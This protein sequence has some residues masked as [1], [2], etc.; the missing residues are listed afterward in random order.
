MP[1]AVVTCRCGADLSGVSPDEHAEFAPTAAPATSSSALVWSAAVVAATLGGVA[2]GAIWFRDASPPRPVE[3]A[4]GAAPPRADLPVDSRRVAPATPAPAPGQSESPLA[5]LAQATPKPLA[6]ATL[7]LPA[8]PREASGIAP[9]PPS[10]EDVLSGV[11]TAVVLVEASGSRGTGF[12]VAPDTLLTNVHVVGRNSTVSIRRMSGETMPARVESTASDVD[13]AVLKIFGGSKEQRTLTLGST[14]DARIGQE[15][16]AIGSA[17]G[18]LENT[19]TRGIVSGVRQTNTATLVQTDAAVNP[20]NSGGPLIDR[21]GKVLGII[22]M[23][24]TQRQ[25]LNFAVGI[26]HARAL[27]DGGPRPQAV[28]PAAPPEMRS[29]SPALASD[30]DRTRSEGRRLYEQAMAQVARRADG[31]DGAWADFRKSCA[32]SRLSG[33]FDREWFALFDGR[34]FQ[35]V[36]PPGCGSW[37]ADFRRHADVVRDAVMTAEEAAR[38]A[39]VYP[40]MRREIRRRH[41]L[42]YSGWDR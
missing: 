11:I 2:F 10:L 13:V 23:G 8:V 31:L 7:D 39:D 17:L 22:T 12:F 16:F 33:S 41:R 26:D 4:A 30:T 3:P 1:V 21:T 38:Q 34:S 5:A 28:R 42:D 27:L 29:L 15:V 20:G 18:M 37:L 19:L 24:F 36:M 32:G 40:G 6:P 35:G 9:N 25:G 14:A